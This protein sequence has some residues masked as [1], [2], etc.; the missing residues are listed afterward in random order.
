LGVRRQETTI[1][2][3]LARHGVCVIST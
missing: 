3:E 2:V 1:P